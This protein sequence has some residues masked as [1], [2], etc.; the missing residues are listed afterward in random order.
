LR[1]LYENDL[2]LKDEKRIQPLLERRFNL[3]LHKMPISYRIDW[4]ATRNGQ[5][6]AV[7]EYK[8]RFVDKNQYDTIF[9]SLSKWNAGLDFVLKNRLAF[10]FVAEWNDG[11][12][13]LPIASMESLNNYNIGFG[14][15][16]AQTRDS[17]DI[18]PVIHLPI[19]E[20]KSL[21]VT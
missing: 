21:E 12:G 10:V 4:F 20:F 15:R 16:T 6:S 5:A 13:Y 19:S 17:G 3:T 2:S 8:R 1:Q 18:E 11:V 7:I 14:G 9:L